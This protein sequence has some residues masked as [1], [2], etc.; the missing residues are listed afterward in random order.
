MKKRTSRKEI[1]NKGALFLHDLCEEIIP[2]FELQEIIKTDQSRFNYE[3]HGNRKLSHGGEGD[4]M[5][6]VQSF[7]LHTHS[8]KIQPMISTA[9]ELLSYLMIVMLEPSG[10]FGP[11]V[12]QTIP[13]IPGVSVTCSKSGKVEFCEPEPTFALLLSSRVKPVS[14]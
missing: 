13:N 3:H 5:A 1:E 14:W 7:S 6:L 9:G 8:Y 10:S 11:R 12:Q 2:N 4:A